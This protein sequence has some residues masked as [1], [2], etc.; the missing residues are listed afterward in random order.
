[1]SLVDINVLQVYELQVYDTKKSGQW[2]GKNISV[3]INLDFNQG[4]YR[5]N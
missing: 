5:L 1:M 4:A 2:A 3:K